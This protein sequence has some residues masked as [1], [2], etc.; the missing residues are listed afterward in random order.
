[1]NELK[2]LSQIFQERIF[3][4]PDYQRGYAW[5][6]AQLRDFWEDIVNLQREFRTV[7]YGVGENSRLGHAD[8][9]IDQF[10]L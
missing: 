9:C 2:S 1:M 3:R 10:L 4:I 6:A 5:Q 7:L 8:P